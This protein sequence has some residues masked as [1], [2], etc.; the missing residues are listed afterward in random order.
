MEKKNYLKPVI[1]VRNIN[2]ESL[3]TNSD[4]DTISI[5]VGGGGVISSGYVDAKPNPTQSKSVW[6]TDEEE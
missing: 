2:S 5:P 6:D 4:P 3:L 1:K